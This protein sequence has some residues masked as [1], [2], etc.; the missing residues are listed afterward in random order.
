[1]PFFEER[2][3]LPK[4][5]CSGLN[6]NTLFEIERENVKKESNKRGR[7]ALPALQSSQLFKVHDSELKPDP[8]RNLSEAPVGGIRQPVLFFSVHKSPFDC[9]AAQGVGILPSGGMADILGLVDVIGSDMP[10]HG[11]LADLVLGAERAFFAG[12]TEVGAAFVFLISSPVGGGVMEDAV[13]RTDA[14]ARS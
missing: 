8:R 9:P 1:M 12:H 5:G 7:T 13:F 14:A 3:R 4:K 10:G 11:L 2:K 6:W